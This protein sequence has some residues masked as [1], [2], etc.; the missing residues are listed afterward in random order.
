MIAQLLMNDYT[1]RIEHNGNGLHAGDQ[2]KVLVI[3]YDTELP[4]WIQT[5]IDHNH[6]TGDWY[7]EACPVYQVDGLFAEV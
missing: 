1:G 4:V 5:T 2:I 6:I 3:D 7:L